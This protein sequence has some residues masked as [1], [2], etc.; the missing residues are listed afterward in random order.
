MLKKIADAD[1]RSDALDAVFQDQSFFEQCQLKYQQAAKWPADPSRQLEWAIESLLKGPER[2]IALAQ[3]HGQR[4]WDE[5]DAEHRREVRSQIPDTWEDFELDM[6]S[7]DLDILE[8]A[9]YFDVV[10][11]CICGEQVIE[12]DDFVDAVFDFYGLR[13]KERDAAYDDLLGALNE[14]GIEDADGSSLCSYHHHMMEK[15][16]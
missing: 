2:A 6:N 10:R 11:S 16:D 15:D 5:I 4:D 9:R 1:V 8:L 14:S 13:E 7:G 3:E 12:F